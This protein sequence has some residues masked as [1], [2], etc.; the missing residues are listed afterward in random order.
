MRRPIVSVLAGLIV[1]VWTVQ[2]THAGVIRSTGKTVQQ[3]SITLAQKTSDAVGTATSGAGD[4]VK[5]TPG[6]LKTGTAAVGKAQHQHRAWPYEQR[7]Q[8]HAR[9]G[10]PFGNGNGEVGGVRPPPSFAHFEQFLAS[11]YRP[12]S[13]R[14]PTSPI[15]KG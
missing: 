14:G 7:R 3:G 10:G 5:A 2:W 4:A 15:S 12:L 11:P 1:L 6:A 13:F 8:L 9:Y